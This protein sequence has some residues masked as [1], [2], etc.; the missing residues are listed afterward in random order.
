LSA[1]QEISIQVEKMLI[2]LLVNLKNKCG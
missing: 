1:A 2:A